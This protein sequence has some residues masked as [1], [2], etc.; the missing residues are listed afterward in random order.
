MKSPKITV[1]GSINMDLITSLSQLPKQGETI[2]G[3]SFTMKPGGKGANQA[4]AAARLG[5][6]VSF[7]GKVGNDALG[8][9]LLANFTNEGISTKSIEVDRDSSTGTA[10][11]LLYEKDNR[12][13]IIPGANKNVTVEFIE[14]SKDLLLSSDIVITQLEIPTE[15][16]S[17]CANLCYEH[18]IPLILNP[19]PA[20]KLPDDIWEKCTYITPNEEEFKQLF[21]EKHDT[22]KVIT[23]LGPSGARFRNKVIPTYPSTVVDTTGAGDTFNGALAFYIASGFQVEE[24][25]LRANIAASLA[26]QKLGAQEG[27]PTSEMVEERLGQLK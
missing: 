10:N 18:D 12:I 17:W 9:D 16:I 1:V 25:I 3:E 21:G 5:A 20:T 11:I 4:V 24:A 15:T 8:M 22:A 26:I 6:N 13:I 23:T 14:K 19:A 27:M 7:I 2:F